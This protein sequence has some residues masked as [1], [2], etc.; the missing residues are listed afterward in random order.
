[1][2]FVH[3]PTDRTIDISAISVVTGYVL[4]DSRVSGGTGRVLD[5]FGVSSQVSDAESW[6][7]PSNGSG[8][9]GIRRN[10]VSP[11]PER[12]HQALVAAT[13]MEN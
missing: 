4:A 11:Y 7:S 12:L 2:H 13:N 10:I 8:L 9:G 6:V 5:R 3:L 1:M